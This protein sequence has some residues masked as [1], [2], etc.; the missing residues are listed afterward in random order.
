[1]D[2]NTLF[3]VG[4]SIGTII[5]GI[6]AVCFVPFAIA[7]YFFGDFWGKV[8]NESNFNTTIHSFPVKKENGD[9]ET[10]TLMHTTHEEKPKEEVKNDV[11]WQEIWE[12][13]F[14]VISYFAIVFGIVSIF[15][16]ILDY[17]NIFNL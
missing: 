14:I 12:T 4:V 16:F 5:L 2:F 3:M 7:E 8:K 13:L 15:F 10:I 6:Y 11:S 17:T 1:M 9:Y